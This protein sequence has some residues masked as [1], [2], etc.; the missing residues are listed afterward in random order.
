METLTHTF[1]AWVAALIFAALVAM[2][3]TLSFLVLSHP[4]RAQVRVPQEC[5][6]LAMKYGRPLAS[7]MSRFKANQAK[8]ELKLLSDDEPL[9]KKCRDAVARLERK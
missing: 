2:A 7:V 6:D 4:V 9:V 8:A 1:L 5:I 3:V